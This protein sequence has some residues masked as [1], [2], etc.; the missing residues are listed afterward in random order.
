MQIFFRTDCTSLSHSHSSTHPITPSVG[1]PLRSIQDE[2]G[3]LGRKLRS[4]FPRIGIYGRVPKS[5]ANIVDDREDPQPT[6]GTMPSCIE[7]PISVWCTGGFG[8]GQKAIVGPGDARVL[9]R[10]DNALGEEPEMSGPVHTPRD[11]RQA[12]TY[13]YGSPVEGDRNSRVWKEPLISSWQYDLGS[14]GDDQY[15]ES[16]H[17][18]PIWRDVPRWRRDRDVSYSSPV[19]QQLL[20]GRNQHS[21][22]AV[23][24]RQREIAGQ[25]PHASGGAAPGDAGAGGNGL[26]VEFAGGRGVG[27]GSEGARNER[28]ERQMELSVLAKTEDGVD[29]LRGVIERLEDKMAMLREGKK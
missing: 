15:L 29:K 8:G 10:R 6:M 27:R 3:E 1:W 13:M 19:E 22:G 2:D 18:L 5:D 17:N 16:G 23:A 21:G 9:G 28:R 26:K 14:K 4:P 24:E 11:L 7:D 12:F 20:A 25:H